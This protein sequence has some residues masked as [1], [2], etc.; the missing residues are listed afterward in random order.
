MLVFI[1]LGKQGI[2]FIRVRQ[3]THEIL[4]MTSNPKLIDF[5]TLNLYIAIFYLYLRLNLIFWIVNQCLVG[6]KTKNVYFIS[7]LLTP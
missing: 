4:I 7:S 6:I 1:L 3:E 5:R 2:K